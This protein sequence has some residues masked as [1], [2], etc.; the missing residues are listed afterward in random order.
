VLKLLH[1]LISQDNGLGFLQALE[2]TLTI[3]SSPSTAECAF[4]ARPRSSEQ[5]PRAVSISNGRLHMVDRVG[6]S[7]VG[8]V[9]KQL[10][11]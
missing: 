2:G 7:V 3:A 10:S 6:S 1:L 5:D 9:Y 8:F 4:H 11:I